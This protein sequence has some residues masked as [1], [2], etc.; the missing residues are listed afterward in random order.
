[1]SATGSGQA[2]ACRKSIK[3]DLGAAPLIPCIPKWLA[4]RA[5]V[6]S[7]A[8]TVHMFRAADEDV[9]TPPKTPGCTT[10]HHVRIFDSPE[11]GCTACWSADILVRSVPG[12][13]TEADKNVRAP[14]NRRWAH[15]SLLFQQ[16]CMECRVPIPTIKKAPA[17]FGRQSARASSSSCQEPPPRSWFSLLRHRPKSAHPQVRRRPDDRQ[18]EVDEPARRRPRT[19]PLEQSP[20]NPGRE[21]G[22]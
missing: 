21:A 22:R 9:R 4:R 16:S 13:K 14:K 10:P 19:R 15:P 1:M 5:D 6:P 2:T 12:L 7:A 18:Y 3:R 20:A 11:A 8:G 17:R